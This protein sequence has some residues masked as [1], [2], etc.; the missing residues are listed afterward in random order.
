[1]GLGHDADPPG[2]TLPSTARDGGLHGAGGIRTG[3][4]SKG[5]RWGRKEQPRV[6][7]ESLEPVRRAISSSWGLEG[8]GERGWTYKREGTQ[9][10]LHHVRTPC[11]LEGPR[12]HLHPGSHGEPANVFKARNDMNNAV[13]KAHFSNRSSLN[14]P[15]KDVQKEGSKAAIEA[16]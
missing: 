11:S 16:T 5:E 1:M 9:E 14:K 10:I 2:D 8:S 4:L 15:G 12:P 13:L 7:W 3:S 6:T